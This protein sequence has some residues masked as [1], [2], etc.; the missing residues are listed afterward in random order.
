MKREGFKIIVRDGYGKKIETVIIASAEEI[1]EKLDGVI[2]RNP[3]RIGLEENI[4]AI[5]ES[6]RYAFD[7][8]E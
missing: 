7:T 3:D 5:K 4:E 8:D 2:E 6:L 1:D